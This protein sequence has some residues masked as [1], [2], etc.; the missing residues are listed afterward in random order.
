M[1]KE[2]T[3]L[4]GVLSPALLLACGSA[5]GTRP[6]DMSAASHQA[7][8]EEEEKQAAAHAQE[9]DPNAA[10]TEPSCTREGTERRACWS[11]SVNPTAEHQKL[12]DEHRELAAKHRAAASALVSAEAAACR[13]IGDMDRDMSP[14]A[15]K[16]DIRSV[17]ELVEETYDAGYGATE[18][19][20]VGASLV[21]NAVPGMT[22]EWLQRVVDCHLARNAALGHDVPEM[23]YCPLVPKGATAKV[24]SVGDGFVVDVRGDS[25]AAIQ[26][27]QRRAQILAPGSKVGFMSSP[28]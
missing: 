5:A 27:I 21:F 12:A 1:T 20:T 9:H 2:I 13:G 25:D 17:S 7:A 24:S 19:R 26:E 23:P 15:H 11:D 10:S 6:H 4:V 28:P 16:A 14:F 3:I 22:A 8:A 18:Q